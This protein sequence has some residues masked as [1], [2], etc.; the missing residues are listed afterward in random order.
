[1]GLRISADT[2]ITLINDGSDE[3]WMSIGHK[4]RLSHGFTRGFPGPKGSIELDQNVEGEVTLVELKAK[5]HLQTKRK[6]DVI[7][8]SL[9]HAENKASLLNDG[10]VQCF[11]DE[12][13]YFTTEVESYPRIEID[14]KSSR[15]VKGAI[16]YLRVDALAPDFNGKSDSKFLSVDTSN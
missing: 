15:V 12:D 16:I 14:L 3:G 2:D 1:M 6:F 13:L 7:D 5:R 10:V 9:G 11:P 8:T 4:K